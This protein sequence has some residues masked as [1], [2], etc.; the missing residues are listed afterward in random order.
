MK[1]AKTLFTLAL[2]LCVSATEVV[3]ETGSQNV[4][5]KNN[6]TMSKMDEQMTAILKAVELY[7]EAGRKGS[8]EIGEKAF[9]EKATMSWVEKGVITTVPI[10]ALFEGLEQTGA[11]E[12]TY[13]V[14]DVSIAGDIA[15]VRIES[16]FSKLGTFD[17][18]FTLAEQDGEWKIV[19]KIYHVK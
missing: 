3:A 19:S 9:T 1:K 10:S 13:K 7:A 4:I 15:F 12:V 11:E 18:M 5:N 6:M 14:V 8:R 2:L 16:Y 17:D